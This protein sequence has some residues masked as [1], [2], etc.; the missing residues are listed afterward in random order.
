MCNRKQLKSYT[1]TSAHKSAQFVWYHGLLG[2]SS[3][4]VSCKGQYLAM[5]MQQII[6][7]FETERY[8]VS[9]GYSQLSRK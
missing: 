4:S 1:L 5:F 9:S 8:S 2:Q 3:C 6:P 7:R